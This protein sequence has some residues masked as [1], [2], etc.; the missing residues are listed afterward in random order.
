M[1]LLRYYTHSMEITQSSDNTLWQRLWARF[2]SYTSVG[3]A[4]FLLDLA[5]IWLF[6]WFFEIREPF[7]IG[8]AFLIAFHINYVLLRFW[9]YQK[10]KEKMPKTYTYFV[11]LAIA[12]TFLLPTLVTWLENL[13]DLEMF[14]ARVLVGSLLGLIGFSFNTFF[15]FKHL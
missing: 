4:T 5:F 13:L 10:S 14:T 15:N 2:S 7:A 11:T 3:F 8:I 1:V 12:V 6:V 9:V